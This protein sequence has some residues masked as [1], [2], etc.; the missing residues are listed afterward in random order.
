MKTNSKIL[1]DATPAP[2][3]VY[4]GA[5]YQFVARL[6]TKRQAQ[7]FKDQ[8]RATGARC[9]VHASKDRWYDLYVRWP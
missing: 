8:Y 3:R 9:R 6:G 7:Q 1:T 5:R 2:Y 4:D